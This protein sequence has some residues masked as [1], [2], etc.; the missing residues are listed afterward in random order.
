MHKFLTFLFPT[1]HSAR[2]V[3]LI[4]FCFYGFIM[5]IMWLK[6][7]F[8][9]YRFGIWFIKCFRN[10]ALYLLYLS[11]SL[12]RGI[13]YFSLTSILETTTKKFCNTIF[14]KFAS[15]SIKSQFGVTSFANWK[16]SP[17]YIRDG[18]RNGYTFFFATIR[19]SYRHFFPLFSFS[20]IFLFFFAF[21]FFF[22]FFF[23][24]ISLCLSDSLRVCF[25]FIVFFALYS[26]HKSSSIGILMMG[27]WL[28]L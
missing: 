27:V 28:A 2:W 4:L 3:F 8:F 12:I 9:N 18:G 5:K 7:L 6:I 13:F 11:I 15:G 23:L 16:H 20:L 14:I 21:F 26:F 17:L 22:Q 25:P 24:K 19:Y 10:D 1:C